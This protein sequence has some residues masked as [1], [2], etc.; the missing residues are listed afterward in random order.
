MKYNIGFLKWFL[1]LGFL[2]TSFQTHTIAQ[3]S[4]GLEEH[5]QKIIRALQYIDIGYIEDVDEEELVEHA[6]RG[7]LKELDPHSVYY[8]REELEKAEE[9]LEGRFEGIGVQFDIIRDTIVVVSPISGGPSEKVGIMSG[10]RIV[11]IDGEESTGSEINNRYVQ[12]K[13]RGEK[14]SEVDVGVIRQ[15]RDD[16]LEF[17]I[18]RDEIPI[19][20]LDAA[21]MATPEIG[22]IKLNRFSRTTMDEFE[23]ALD[24]LREEGMQDLILDLNYNSGGYLD[25]A[26]KLTDQFFDQD[27]LITYVDGRATPRRD[28]DSSSE[29]SFKDGD[30]VVMVNEG[31]A[32]ASEILAGAVQDWDRGFIVGRRTFGKGL[33]QRPFDLPDGSA[34]RLTTAQYYTPS[35][36]S[37]QKPYDEGAE[38][39]YKE[40]SQRLESGELISPEN[41]TFPDS[42]KYETA[43]GR[44]V[45]GGGGIMPD[46]Y[47][48]IDTAD[49]VSDYFSELLQKGIL[50]T[51]SFEYSNDNRDDLLDNYPEFEKFKNEFKIDEGIL[52]KL[53]TYAETHE[54]EAKEDE[55]DDFLKNRL[56][57]LIARNLWDISAS[58]QISMDKDE[59]FQK[60]LQILQDDKFSE[61]NIN[62]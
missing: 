45:Y 46:Y 36:R 60:A 2:L 30:L 23:E 43:K 29:G 15:G 47:I 14:G 32:S 31:S 6:I 50:N 27:K 18:T 1:I 54:I 42:L 56:K 37:I 39:Y 13:L 40:L 55:V 44:T 48:P 25:V 19:N 22:Y 57:A 20:S 9:P 28:F 12:D 52:S 11:K 21:F 62:Q 5:H 49:R 33:V 8:S 34:I 3:D 10:D 35:G 7:I 26:I 51:F 24:N 58:I 59:G 4:N 53:E 17:T 38:E 41:I 61:Q 16:I